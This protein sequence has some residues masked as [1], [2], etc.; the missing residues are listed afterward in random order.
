LTPAGGL[1]TLYTFGGPDGE[2]PYGGLLQGSDGSLYGTTEKAGTQND[3]TVFGLSLGTNSQP[4]LN[5][6]TGT[7]VANAAIVPAGTGGMVTAYA[8]TDTDLLID[9]NGYF[10]ATGQ[11][12]L[13][14]YPVVPCRVIDMRGIG[15]GQPFSGTLSPPVDVVDSNCGLP[16][17][18]QAYVFNATALPSPT[19]HYLTLWPDQQPV[20]GVSTL[21][22]ID[23]LVTSNMAIV[24]TTNGKVE[25][26]ASGTT[27]LILDI[28]SY[29][30]P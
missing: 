29:F 16:G 18:A 12:G 13:S 30:A 7:Y 2:F 5:N 4:T 1:T 3:G 15:S 10:S 21:N 26:F 17:S 23:G 19:L 6:P 9:I 8:S 25:A 14:L 27:Q 20:P 22:A 28:F 11:G 24:P